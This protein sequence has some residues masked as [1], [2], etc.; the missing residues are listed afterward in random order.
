MLFM[1]KIKY[2]FLSLL[3]SIVGNVFAQTES[4]NR[5]LDA[6]V[7]HPRIRQW[8]FPNNGVSVSPHPSLLWPG[9]KGSNTVYKIQLSQDS[10]F[11]KDVIVG[12]E[13]VWAVYAVHKAL[14]TGKWFWKYAYKNDRKKNWAW[15]ESYSFNV[16][17]D[18]SSTNTPTVETFLQ[19]AATVHPRL[20]KINDK[21]DAFRN[22]NRNNP[23]AL[24]LLKEA[25]KLLHFTGI[26]EAPTRPRDTAGVSDE[27][28]ESLIEFMYH[29]FG[30]KNG[31][32]IKTLV[33][34]YWL[35]GAR[36]YVDA[37]ITR[38]LVLATLNHNALATRDDF[39]NANV[40]EALAWAYDAGYDFLSDSQ[41]KTLRESIKERGNRIYNNVVNRFELQF[42]DNHIWQHILRNF[43]IAAVAVVKDIPDANQWLSYIYEVWSARFPTLGTTDGGAFDGNGY[44]RV[45]F[46]TLVYLPYLLG[47]I[48]GVDYYKNQWLQNLPY[49][50]IYSLPAG[51]PST[52]YGDMHEDLNRPLKMQARF[53][54]ALSREVHNPY[55]DSYVASLK[56]ESPAYFE[57]N[58][59]F[60]FFR[61]LTN[62]Q[63]KADRNAKISLPE[64]SRFFND[65]GLAALHSDLAHPDKDAAVYLNV[66]PFGASG[67]GH[68]A[69]NAFTLN[70]KGLE[71]STGT[72]YYT[73]FSD[74][75]TLLHY[76][77]AR[78][79]NT[80]LA[81]SIGQKLGEEGYGWLPRGLSGHRIQY[82]LGDASSAYGNVASTFWLSHFT[83]NKIVP[84]SAN[85]YGDP[86]VKWNRRH[87]LLLDSNYIIV[88]DE[89]QSS[90]NVKWTWQFH[91]NYPLQKDKE[92]LPQLRNVSID[93]P[94]LGKYN[95]SLLS[96]APLQLSVHDAFV[97]PALNWKGKKNDEEGDAVEYKK[98][99]HAGFSTADKTP[100][101]RFIGVIALNAR[102]VPLHI[103]NKNGIYHFS[104][105]NWNV[106]ATLDAGQSPFLQVT[107]GDGNAVFD[108]G[109]GEVNILNGNERIAHH[110]KGSSLLIEKDNTGK[111][112]WKEAIDKWPDVATQDR[113]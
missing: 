87:I 44:F 95:V 91:S 54:E 34:A 50:L 43:S 24:A 49:Y 93:I 2:F 90:K 71:L 21:L 102:D 28:K 1:K 76:R 85:G 46:E 69:Q 14:K 78:A 113:P 30:E 111:Y 56:K 66:N 38:A 60:R 63:K 67:H 47:Q 37:A 92:T 53:A 84:D 42:C 55:L 86:G 48:S 35:T 100:A 8:A 110:Y 96:P 97:S 52:G 74:A 10:L 12:N 109:S 23:E 65:I 22:A 106:A 29:G 57:G 70:Y 16:I 19:E 99:W 73:N 83:K 31:T 107:S 82:A 20:W 36:K 11:A 26:T 59:Q 105:G 75:H 6:A 81:D 32:P 94:K 79:Y 18:S 25:D 33:Q 112:E 45:H 15:S 61:L 68:A 13:Q 58:D 80:I 7:L 64:R 39:N 41:K 72:G 9:A 88:Y 103:Q 5:P 51:E 17:K 27:K 3:L 108:Y 89:L 104:I 62:G 98:Q 4:A 40:L 77:S 101:F